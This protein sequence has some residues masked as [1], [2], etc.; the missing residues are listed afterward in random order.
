VPFIRY[1]RDKRGYETTF[2]MHGYRPAQG[3]QRTR[4]LYLFR[5]PSHIRMG[6][7]PLDEESR[8]ALEHTHP[9]LSFDWTV[10]GRESE[11]VRADDRDRYRDRDGVRG[12]RPPGR[13]PRPAP[14]A[15]APAAVDDQSLLGRTLG[16][17]TA[18]R[19]R[20]RYSELL[21][22]ITRRARTPE[23]RD[24]LTELAQRLNPDDWPDAEAVRAHAETIEKAW[25]AV[26]A[27]L[28]AR[29]RGRRGGR[30]REG[31]AED[32]AAPDVPSE[33]ADEVDTPE[34][35]DASDIMA[36][37]GEVDA[38]QHDLDPTDDSPARDAGAHTG[39]DR[40]GAAAGAA[41]DDVQGDDKLRQD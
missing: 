37:D 9:D 6:R 2:V 18:A 4:V 16:G 33:D 40:A 27:E 41:G 36:G 3:P 10:L 28:P 39:G 24:R 25:D 21:Q 19:F 26:A 13:G 15:A 17:D 11:A 8:E 31:A 32:G 20:S 34:A 14:P 38:R 5:A 1:T 23:E 22:R 7:R 12:R 30:R 29:R 35:V